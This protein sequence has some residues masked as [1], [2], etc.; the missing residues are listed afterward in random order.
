MRE[1]SRWARSSAPR[2]RCLERLG[3]RL[4]GPVT[5][6]QKRRLIEILVADIRVD[7]VE[8]GGVKQS[9]VTVTYRFSQPDE[10][11]PL[12]LP[13][14][15]TTGSVIRIPA[16]PK[17]VGDH[18][19]KKRLAMKLL[20]KDVAKQIGVGVPPFSTGEGPS[21][22]DNQYMPAII[23]FLGYNRLPEGRTWGE[24]LVRH[25]DCN[26]NITEGSGGTYGR[27][28]GHAGQVGAR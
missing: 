28:P 21:Q 3:T 19:R 8:T 5:F 9:E 11:L 6:E 2:K 7:T 13:Q 15:Y 4:D 12:I 25:R 14:S 24:R 18:I 20:Q 26:R 1:Q 16:V 10:P 27:G 23:R 22:P 17:T